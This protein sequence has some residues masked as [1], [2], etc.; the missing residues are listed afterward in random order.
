MKKLKGN[1][2]NHSLFHAN[3]NNMFQRGTGE[4]FKYKAAVK[5]KFPKAKCI[6]AYNFGRMKLYVVKNEGKELSKLCHSAEAAWSDAYIK[7]TT[8]KT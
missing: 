4:R 5:E 6:W 3:N 1:G 8:N 2:N 7:N